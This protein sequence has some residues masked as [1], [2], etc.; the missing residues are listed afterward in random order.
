MPAKKKTTTKKP[1]APK[2]AQAEMNFNLLFS[3][4]VTTEDKLFDLA[5]ALRHLSDDHSIPV[6][7]RKLLAVIGDS[8]TRLACD[9]TMT[10]EDVEGHD[11]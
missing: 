8:A 11:A 9:I 10:L 6:G 7:P 5:L 2:Q 4:L 1:A 3:E